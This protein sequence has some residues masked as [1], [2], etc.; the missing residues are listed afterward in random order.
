MCHASSCTRI[1]TS[2]K[3]LE[4]HSVIQV[5]LFLNLKNFKKVDILEEILRPKLSPQGTIISAKLSH[6]V[7]FYSPS[8]YNFALLIVP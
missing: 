8:K 4:L 6:L 3:L 1:L 5:K 7:Q 2:Q